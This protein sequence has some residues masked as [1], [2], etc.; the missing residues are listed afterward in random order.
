MSALLFRA[1]GSIL[2]WVRILPFRLR[3]CYG[4]SPLQ[5][6]RPRLVDGASDTAGAAHQHATVLVGETNSQPGVDAT[7]FVG[8]SLHFLLWAPV[9]A[10]LSARGA[11]VAWITLPISA[12][13]ICQGSTSK[14]H[15][16]V[17]GFH[18]GLDHAQTPV[19]FYILTI[20]FIGRNH[21]PLTS[22]GSPCS[23]QVHA[24]GPSFLPT[25][26][27]IPWHGRPADHL[28]CVQRHTLAVLVACCP[29]SEGEAFEATWRV[30]RQRRA[31]R[32][33]VLSFSFPK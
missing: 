25:C 16:H 11:S 28:A 1:R 15:H 6:T 33:R 12:D 9:A 14:A 8:G 13:V 4:P 23:L 27:Q 19:Q 26:H 32:K 24:L 29:R 3:P 7:D 5:S 22:T 20:S 10:P 31:F 17:D 18:R 30:V 2:R 21:T